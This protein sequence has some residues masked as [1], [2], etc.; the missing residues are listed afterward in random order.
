[1]VSVTAQ[2]SNVTQLSNAI[3]LL[4]LFSLITNVHLKTNPIKQ[5]KTEDPI[6][7]SA[8]KVNQIIQL[9][10]VLI[11][12]LILIYLRLCAVNNLNTI[13]RADYPFCL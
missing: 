5:K 7:S 12:N 3:K 6:G 13:T 1:M 11:E 10:I 8:L 4:R 9:Q 2:Q